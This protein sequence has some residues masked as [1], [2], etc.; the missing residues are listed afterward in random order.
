MNTPEALSDYAVV[1][2]VKVRWSDLDAGQIVNNVQ[3]LRWLEIGRTDMLEQ[4]GMTDFS[5]QRVAIGVVVGKVSCTYIA[6]VDYPDTILVGSRVSGLQADRFTVENALFSSSQNR[7][8]GVAEVRLV[9]FDLQQMKKALIP[10][11]LWKGLERMVH[12]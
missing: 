8:V 5:G 10:D 9:S 2:P 11:D 6:P 4:A 3:Y 12:E 7:L 1:T